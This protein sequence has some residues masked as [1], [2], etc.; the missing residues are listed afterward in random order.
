[1]ACDVSP[2]Q[3]F[4]SSD[5]RYRIAGPVALGTLHTLALLSGDFDQVS[6]RG[7]G[8]WLLIIEL[9]VAD[10]LRDA[11]GSTLRR[12]EAGMIR[13]EIAFEIVESKTP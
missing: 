7:D 2:S 12:F 10:H 13:H 1:M 11:I 4:F 5:C 9:R 6:I 8:H 3:T